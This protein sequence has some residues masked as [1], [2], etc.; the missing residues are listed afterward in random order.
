MPES[1]SSYQAAETYR[2]LLRYVAKY[3][4]VF[5]I[6]ILGMIIEAGGS[7]A[8]AAM[9]KPMLD[10]SF[11]QQDPDIIKYMPIALVAVFL[12]RGFGSFAAETQMMRV[13][14]NV[15]RDLRQHLFAHMLVLPT[16][17]YDSTPSSK[18]IAQ[19]IYDTEQV[20]SAATKSILILVRDSLTIVGLFGLMLYYNWQLSLFFVLIGPALGL[21]V[22]Y[23]SRRLR[24]IARR[25]QTSMGDVTSVAQEAIDGH[26]VIKIYGTQDYERKHFDDANRTTARQQMKLAITGALAGPITLLI[27]SFA[28][29]AV[30]YIVTSQATQ[31]A[32]TVGTFMSFMT[33]L[34]LV[35]APLKR[36][37]QVNNTTQRGIAAAQGIFQFLDLPTEPDLGKRTLARAKGRI[38]FRDVSFS[39]G[40][41]SGDVLERVT[42]TVEPG[43]T[44]ALVGKSGSGKST[45]V[46]LLPRFYELSR[47]TILLDDIDIREYRL[48]ELRN[49]IAYV[50][51][52]VVL[53]NDTVAQN[54]SYGHLAQ[55]AE[56]ALEKAAEA[57]HAREFIHRLPQGFDTLIGEK[58]VLLS[59]GQRQRIA[60]AR[61][62]LKDAPV[63]ILDEATSAL[64][65][66]SE[67]HI[68]AALE[69]LTTN[70]TTLV[71]AHRLST[72]ERADRIL[73][74]DAGQIVEQ[75]THQELLAHNGIYAQLHRR[76]FAAVRAQAG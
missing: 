13:G 35:F 33:A 21:L 74:L 3:W 1:A 7:T 39:Y 46:N 24:R 58:G 65:S 71:I 36:L 6:A 16:P 10:G 2:R 53:F 19:L 38:E 75:G 44:V 69:N 32:F 64:D 55:N 26:R 40:T 34:M 73:V 41:E 8:F 27:G 70:R 22:R 42:F 5:A 49:Q 31:G 56:G 12:I 29:A 23:I 28:F 25:I 18:L 9:V 17:H 51:Q 59:G 63:L 45:I 62:L 50:S 76:Q 54:I 67:Y 66:E 4:R 61:A 57:A 15:T 52:D 43:Q 20:F 72:I 68:Q 30:L 60:I 48:A 14:R 37:T 47:G 11:V